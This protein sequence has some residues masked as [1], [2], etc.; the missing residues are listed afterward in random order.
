[1]CYDKSGE[2]TNFG[3]ADQSGTWPGEEV[4]KIHFGVAKMFAQQSGVRSLGYPL[5]D[6]DKLA[7]AQPPPQR[8]DYERTIS[9]V[10]IVCSHTCTC[11]R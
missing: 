5:A 10:P 4:R 9:Y 8:R 11:A 1:M 2:R 7:N 6:Y 3:Q